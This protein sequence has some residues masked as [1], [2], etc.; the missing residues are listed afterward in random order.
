MARMDAGDR[1]APDP[2]GT[3]RFWPGRDPGS[4]ND[5]QISKLVVC[6]S[7]GQDSG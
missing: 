2:G 3:A 4:L 7:H 5:A 1:A 6:H